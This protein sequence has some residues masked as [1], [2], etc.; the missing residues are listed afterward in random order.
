[1][2]TETCPCGGTFTFEVYD[3]GE[4][5]HHLL[6]DIGSIFAGEKLWTDA[7]AA[8]RVKSPLAFIA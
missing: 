7:T 2:I 8:A 1:M 6:D 5:S 3:A 4:P